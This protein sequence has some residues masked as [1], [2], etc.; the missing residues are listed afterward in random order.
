M[1]RKLGGGGGRTMDL[2]FGGGQGTGQR[3]LLGQ[4]WGVGAMDSWV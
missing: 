3:F 4:I 1:D 2:K